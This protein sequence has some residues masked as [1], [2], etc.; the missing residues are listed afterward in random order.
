MFQIILRERKNREMDP[1][2]SR[3]DECLN[4]AGKKPETGAGAAEKASHETYVKR[5]SELRDFFNTFDRLFS[6]LLDNQPGSLVK[7]AKLI[8]KLV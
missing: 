6:T 5:V 1:L 7:A 3:L 4:H 8:D 2:L